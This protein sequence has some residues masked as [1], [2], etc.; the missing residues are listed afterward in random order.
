MYNITQLYECRTPKTA[1]KAKVHKVR[2]P[3][4]L[5]QCGGFGVLL[6]VLS[7]KPEVL[8]KCLALTLPDTAGQV[9]VQNR[10]CI[11]VIK[12]AAVRV[13][14]VNGHLVGTA[15][16]RNVLFCKCVGLLEQLCRNLEPLLA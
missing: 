12:S 3:F 9:G 13:L 8:L 10:I 11:N 1:V 6:A 4:L 16:V 7:N 2:E 5:Q 14:V 15:P